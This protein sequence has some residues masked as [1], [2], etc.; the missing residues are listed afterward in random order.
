MSTRFIG[1]DISGELKKRPDH[2]YCVATRTSNKGQRK[3]IVCLTRKRIEELRT[4]I[5]D[6]QE[7]LSAI[8][9]FRS[10]DCGAVLQENYAI[11]IDI[12]WHGITRKKVSRYLK[13]SFG[14]KNYGKGYRADPPFDF[15]PKE[16]SEAVRH[17]DRK[18]SEARGKD[19]LMKPDETDPPI[20]DLLE[21]LEHARKKGIV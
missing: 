9:I 8:L 4:K 5:P 12:D 11:H 16:L 7:K 20:D 3:Y 21:E 14:F 1:V 2:V 10:L 18:A 17:A 19:S 13:R 15:I 6:W